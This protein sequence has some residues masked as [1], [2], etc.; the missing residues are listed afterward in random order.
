MYMLYF[1]IVIFLDVVEKSA[2]PFF[3]EEAF[4]PRKMWRSLKINS[5]LDEDPNMSG[6]RALLFFS[7]HLQSFEFFVWEFS[8]FYSWKREEVSKKSC[9]F[10][11][12]QNARAMGDIFSTGGYIFKLRVRRFSKFERRWRPIE[13]FWHQNFNDRLSRAVKKK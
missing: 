7:R 12:K 6:K 13:S 8:D 5:P 2:V 11:E 3:G 10:D 4:L 9:L 1:Q